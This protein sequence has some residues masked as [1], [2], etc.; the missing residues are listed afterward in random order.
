MKLLFDVTPLM[1][2]SLT[3]VGV[4]TANLLQGLLQRQQEDFRLLPTWKASRFR[5]RRLLR[6]HLSVRTSPYLPFISDLNIQGYDLFH[7]PDFKLPRHGRLKKVVT[8]HDL[9]VYQE[10]LLDERFAAEGRVKFETMLFGCRPDRIITVS[11]F[12]RNQLIERFP[13]FEAITHAIPLGVN[14]RLFPADANTPSPAPSFTPDARPYLLFVGAVERR[15]NL[16]NIIKATELLIERGNNLELKI[17]GGDGYDAQAINQQ[18]R[19]SRHGQRMVRIGF[20]SNGELSQ[21]YQGAVGFLYP[22]LYEGFGLPILEAMSAGCPVITSNC[23]AMLEVS[24][25]AA[26]HA[27]PNSPESIAA[28]AEVLL[29]Q[30]EVRENLV[31]AGKAHAA[32]FGWERCV[33][34][35]VRV[36]QELVG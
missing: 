34:E 5:Q 19:E 25:R 33:A 20:V 14:S 4:Y 13:Q 30:S 28:Q 23:G 7:G 22:S 35:T 27:D 21:L 1:R 17:V 16:R 3:G 26:L 2:R 29:Q 15:K 8:V 36:Y 10:G 9:G 18:I 6:H 11:K 24:G 31:T 12:T 32:G